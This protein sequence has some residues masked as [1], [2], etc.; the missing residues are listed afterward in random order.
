MGRAYECKDVVCPFYKYEKDG[1][2][3]C[4]GIYK[5]CCICQ[6]FP[7]NVSKMTH[8]VKYCMDL[9]GYPTCPLYKAGNEKYGEVG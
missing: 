9:A 3:Y 8:K 5:N 2:L 7:S 1:K 6:S 4:E